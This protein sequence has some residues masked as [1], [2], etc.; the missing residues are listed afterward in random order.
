MAVTYFAYTLNNTRF[1]QIQLYVTAYFSTQAMELTASCYYALLPY[2]SIT[3]P[4]IPPT[5]PSMYLLCLRGYRHCSADCKL[6]YTVHYA[7]HYSFSVS[8][9]KHY[10]FSCEVGDSSVSGRC[11]S[12]I[13][14]H[15]GLRRPQTKRHGLSVSVANATKSTDVR[16][17]FQTEQLQLPDCPC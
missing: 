15:L 10:G 16:N 9:R 8:D 3:P 13:S 6:D 1:A 14:R 7:V 11:V 17:C 4:L 12:G 2:S 5:S